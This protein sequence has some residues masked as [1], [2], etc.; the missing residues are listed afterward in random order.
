MFA[1]FSCENACC[2]LPRDRAFVLA[3]IRDKWGSEEAFDRRLRSCA[4]SYPPC[5]SAPRRATS[6][7]WARS[8]RARSRCCLARESRRAPLFWSSYLA[9]KVFASPPPNP[10]NE[11][12]HEAE[13]EACEQQ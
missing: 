3:A 1:T 4:R 6:G 8:S 7:A 9:G 12:K 11:S 10:S 5:S 13:G 2:Y